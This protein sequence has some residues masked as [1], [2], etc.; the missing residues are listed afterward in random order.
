[1]QIF[2]R[3]ANTLAKVSIVGTLLVV[4]LVG[5]AAIALNR[6][7]WIRETGDALE[8]PVPF[9]HQHHVQALGI[10]CRYCH[11]TVEKSS[12]AGI[13]PT[14]TCMNCHSQIWTNAEMLEP[15]RA[16]FREEV[17]LEWAR[18]HRLADFVKFDHSI[19]VNKGIGCVSCHGQV[20]EMRLTAQEKPLSMSWC[21]D[22][23]RH[24][25]KNLRPLDRITDMN[26][27]AEDQEALGAELAEEYGTRRLDSCSSC[28]Y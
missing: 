19:H 26:W 13:P 21:L 8:Q 23:H 2:H 17:P 12:F 25:E 3:S 5:G 15:V 11:T 7:S 9:S 28:H 18:V 22:C 24:P 4:T 14:Q 27:E 16:S 10:D 6:A 1:M 20:D